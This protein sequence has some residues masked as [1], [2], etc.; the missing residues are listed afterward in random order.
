MEFRWQKYN[1]LLVLILQFGKGDIDGFSGPATFS[2]NNDI[3]YPTLEALSEL[4]DQVSVTSS[5]WSRIT[6]DAKEGLIS[7]YNSW[8]EALGFISLAP[9]QYLS[10]ILDGYAAMASKVKL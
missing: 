10:L 4:I 6:V 8:G 2:F 9:H 7:A 5:Y 1:H 3:V